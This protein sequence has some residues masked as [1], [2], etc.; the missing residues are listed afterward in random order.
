[1]R[2]YLLLISFIAVLTIS[3]Q[4]SAIQQK[5]D[6]SGEWKFAV[7]PGDKGISE[8]WFYQ[9]L[10]DKVVLPGSMSTGCMSV[11]RAGMPSSPG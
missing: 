2:Y 4:Q 11:V 10:T 7:D 5:I 9:S 3:C 6:L 8:K 1:M